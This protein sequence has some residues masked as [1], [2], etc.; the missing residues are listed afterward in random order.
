MMKLHESQLIMFCPHLGLWFKADT[1]V[2]TVV[3]RAKF[4]AFDPKNE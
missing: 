1:Q 4:E 3:G 2:D